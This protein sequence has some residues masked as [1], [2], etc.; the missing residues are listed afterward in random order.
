[1]I[2]PD[3]LTHSIGF[4]IKSP[5]AGKSTEEYKSMVGS[6]KKIDSMSMMGGMTG[7]LP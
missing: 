2:F 5:T 3:P 4:V 1:M 7:S 6:N